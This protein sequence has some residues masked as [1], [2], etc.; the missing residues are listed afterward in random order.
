MLYININMYIYNILLCTSFYNLLNVRPRKVNPAGSGWLQSKE[1]L[2]L[3][4][5]PQS[6]PLD[7]TTYLG[8][9][10]TGF[11]RFPHPASSSTWNSQV[12]MLNCKGESCR[13]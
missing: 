9:H 7:E 12:K 10:R 11:V 3:F 2:V 4:L 5:Y 1:M 13:K 8:H 6:F